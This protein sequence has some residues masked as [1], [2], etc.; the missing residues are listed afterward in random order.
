MEI[1][2]STRALNA[3]KRQAES[4][5]ARAH[6]YYTVSVNNPAKKSWQQLASFLG[7]S[8]DD[9]FTR[10]PFNYD[11]V[12]LWTRF[13]IDSTEKRLV[14]ELE[15]Q[16][17]KR[18]TD[19]ALLKD[20]KS[21]TTFGNFTLLLEQQAVYDAITRDFFV[22]KV[23]RAAYNDGKTGA[24]KTVLAT[25]I[26]DY[27]YK[28]NLLP[29]KIVSYA[30]IMVITP[31]SVM[32]SWSRHIEI[33]G[34]GSK[35]GTEIIVT[36][37]SQLTATYGKVFLSESEDPYTEK[38]VTKWNPALVPDLVILDEGHKLKNESQQTA[39]ILALL[40][41]VANPPYSLW[42]SAT[43]FTVVNN[44]RAFAI[45]TRATLLG[46]QITPDN[47]KQFAALIT[48]EPSKP[49]KAAAK[50]VREI[51][52]NY[53]YS[54]PKSKW[55]HK[56]INSVKMVSFK[57]DFDKQLYQS[58]YERYLEKCS[59]LGKNT[60]F[61]K[62]ERY[63]ALQQFRVASEPLRGEQMAELAHEIVQSGKA[64]PVIGTA[65]RSTIVR[66]VFR[67]AELGYTRK[68]ISIIWGG[69]EEI[70]ADLVLTDQEIQSLLTKPARGEEL[71]PL[72]IKRIKTTLMFREDKLSYQEANDDITRA[73]HN[74]LFEWGLM[75]AQNANVRQKEIDAFQEG[76]SKI[77]LFTLAAGGVG[78][79][80]DHWKESLKPRIGFFTPTYNGE[81]I[82]QALGR[83]PRRLTLSD[84]YQFIVG[85]RDT[86]EEDHV[87]PKLDLKLQ[88]ISTIT[89]T[90]DDLIDFENAG[91]LTSK[92][93][94]SL[95]EAEKDAEKP[96]AQLQ[97]DGDDDEPLDENVDDD[98]D[99]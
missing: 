13:Y 2:F 79:S 22:T 40:T 11:Q 31:K 58:A 25:A 86:V 75:G 9:I 54:F 64:S 61:G 53:I 24:G 16:G 19:I 96:E 44:I 4:I 97:D 67:L 74:K 77:C 99:L 52:G 41:T 6:N 76:E 70:K 30:R 43:P 49:N 32:E 92:T 60:K 1:E 50:R 66:V 8:I 10:N 59:K 48:D 21:L 57:R 85:L 63:V 5:A 90:D 93:I 37:Y 45:A 18:T 12:K 69:K 47:F 39:A 28:N 94:R 23:T 7:I 98:K 38:I 91:Q 55:K 84:T 81:E 27:M 83:L 95:N 33:A 42:L 34:Y 14:A 87:M 20:I 78:L 46:M 72:D 80:L 17:L 36:S 35:L 51:L 82:K 56:A 29:K 88:C 68:D 15:G 3:A 26:I 73:R 89:G 65:F 71:T 62:F